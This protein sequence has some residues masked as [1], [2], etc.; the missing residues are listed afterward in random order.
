MI[1]VPYFFL[2]GAVRL[3]G[4]GGI[5]SG[6]AVWSSDGEDAPLVGVVSKESILVQRYCV[7]TNVRWG[8]SWRG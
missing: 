8:E 4:S 3:G 7:R 1:P 2:F 6:C 5:G